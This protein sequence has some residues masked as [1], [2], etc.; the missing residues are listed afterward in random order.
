MP[1]WIPLTIA[2]AFAQNIR[3]VLQKRLTAELSTS[4][5]TYCRFV[6]AVPFALAYATIMTR[7]EPT[8]VIGASFFA[9]CIV[10]GMAQILGTLCLV[11]AF[12]Y[13]NF[14]VATGYS[15]T[16]T[17]QTACFG[18]LILGDAVST[19]A[20]IAILISLVGVV[21]VSLGP[22]SASDDT[23]SGRPALLG[24][25]SGAAYGVAAVSYRAASLDLALE[26]AAVSASVT[27]AT[28]ITL[29]TLVM[30]A[31]LLLRNRDELRRVI[32][33]WRPGIWV[34][35]TGMAASVGWFTAMTLQ[36]AAYVRALG[37]VEL[38]FSFL[39]SSLLLGERTTRREMGGLVLLLVGVVALVLSET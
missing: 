14:A 7:D 6:Y 23:P 37:Q 31:Y 4:G 19:G 30:G 39:S 34:G 21:L 5:A 10:G 1:I 2:A 16:E 26:R 32:S 8:M 33:G 27:L 9:Y 28:V 22:R 36:N 38:L 29:Q 35:A 12:S 24:L 20:A 13:R 15:K 17:V 11:A 18:I 3:S 25:A